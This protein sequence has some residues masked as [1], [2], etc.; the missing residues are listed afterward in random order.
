MVG[1]ELTRCDEEEGAIGAEKALLSRR[2]ARRKLAPRKT[3]SSMVVRNSEGRSTSPPAS[4]DTSD[5][6][7]ACCPLNMSVTIIRSELLLTNSNN[8]GGAQPAFLNLNGILTTTYLSARSIWREYIYDTH[9]TSYA[10]LV[11]MV[12]AVFIQSGDRNIFSLKGVDLIIYSSLK[13]ITQQQIDMEN[14]AQYADRQ[15]V[16]KLVMPPV[17]AQYL[18][19]CQLYFI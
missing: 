9:L 18:A 12:Y 8:Y 5:L 1:D 2:Q 16:N 4:D 15:I 11:L 3:S 7:A 13:N 10:Y 19:V 6:E 17:D 14:R